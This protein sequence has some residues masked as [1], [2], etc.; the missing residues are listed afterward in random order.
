MLPSDDF[1]NRARTALIQAICRLRKHRR[2]VSQTEPRSIPLVGKGQRFVC[3]EPQTVDY[4]VSGE[5]GTHGGEAVLPAGEV[6]V[7]SFDVRS[8]TEYVYLY[9]TRRAGLA[10]QILNDYWY[11]WGEGFFRDNYYLVLPYAR[12][13][14]VFEVV[15]REESTTNRL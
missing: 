12:F 5:F 8:E 4:M 6:T 7:C 14:K 1:W 11:G 2:P 9:P 15:D 3:T 10:R 13:T